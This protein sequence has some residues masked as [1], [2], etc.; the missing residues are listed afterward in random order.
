MTITD[1]DPETSMQALASPQWSDAEIID[2]ITSYVAIPEWPGA[3]MLEGIAEMISYVRPYPGSYD[4]HGDYAPACKAATERAL[5][6]P[7]PD[8]QRGP[9][10]T[11]YNPT[12]LR[13]ELMPEHERAILEIFT[14][15]AENTGLFL[16]GAGAPIA[17]WHI[18]GAPTTAEPIGVGAFTTTLWA[19]MPW[20]LP[21]ADSPLIWPYADSAPAWKGH[22]I[23]VMEVTVH[24]LVDLSVSAEGA[25]LSGAEIAAAL[26][27][28]GPGR[29]FAL[30]AH[31]ADLPVM[32]TRDLEGVWRGSGCGLDLEYQGPYPMTD[33]RELAAIR[34][35][36]RGYDTP[37]MDG[38]IP[39]SLQPWHGT[40]QRQLL[41]VRSAVAV[42]SLPRPEGRP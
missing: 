7:L 38:D 37:F 8:P 9:P 20:V 25:R 27:E 11:V 31:G 41:A 17:A 12:A 30:G 42:G 1:P 6:L 35:D 39:H 24:G 5:T 29:F 33:E 3:D 36:P 10:M 16:D 23:P 40:R 21:E 28:A 32:I 26:N 4:H 22:E 14:P 18:W 34:E 19:D 2:Q 15:G 13:A